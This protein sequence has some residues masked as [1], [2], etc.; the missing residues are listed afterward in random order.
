MKADI[1]NNDPFKDI[2][3]DRVNA[4]IKTMEEEEKYIIERDCPTDISH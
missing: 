3:T 1:V 2:D 4:D